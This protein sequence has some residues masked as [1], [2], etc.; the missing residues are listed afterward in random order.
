MKKLLKIGVVV[1]ILG[2]IALGIGFINHGNKN[3][4]FYGSRPQVSSKASSRTVKVNRKF[5]QVD[6]DV[7]TA[8]VTV[9]RGNKFQ[10]IYHG[11][12]APQIDVKNGRATIRQTGGNSNG[13]KLSSSE[14]YGTDTVTIVL[15]AGTQLAGKIHV[16]EGDLVVNKTSLKQL[17]AAVEEGDVRLMNVVTDGGKITLN[18]GDFTAHQLTV[19]HHFKVANDEGDNTVQGVSADGYYLQTDEGD[20]TLFHHEEDGD[21]SSVLQKNSHATNVLT[22]VTSEGDNSIH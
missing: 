4:T 14:S 1:L 5:S 21:D 20:N 2:L 9:T 18:E 13:F 10:I 15:P 3:V 11:K 8:N 22:L 17:T 7:S 16:S 19:N 6:V 12:N